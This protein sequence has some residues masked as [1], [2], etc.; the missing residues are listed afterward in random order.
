MKQAFAWLLVVGSLACVAG[1][2]YLLLDSY[3]LLPGQAATFQ[4]DSSA[5]DAGVDRRRLFQR[6]DD[7]AA[8]IAQRELAG[9]DVSRSVEAYKE[10]LAA[11]EA[12][13]FDEVG[14]L[15][16]RA[17][18]L[19]DAPP[20]PPPG[21]PGV[22]PSPGQAASGAPLPSIEELEARL[23]PLRNLVLEVAELDPEAD[24]LFGMLDDAYEALSVGDRKLATFRVEELER[25]VRRD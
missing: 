4:V 6:K 13:R 10:A 17:E 7:L 22:G 8:K 19:L 23:Q 25:E 9:R 16:D 20:P 15:F 11:F 21:Q 18:D 2:A 5:V 1:M 12:R 24:H 14:S 3:G